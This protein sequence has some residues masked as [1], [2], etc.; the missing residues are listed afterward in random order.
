MKNRNGLVIDTRTIKAIGTV[1]RKATLSMLDD[2]TG[3]HQIRLR[4]GKSYDSKDFIVRLCS[5]NTIFLE[6]KFNR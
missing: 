1:E 4:D 3:S 6:E 2:V 5:L